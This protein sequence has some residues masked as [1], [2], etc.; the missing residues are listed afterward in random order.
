MAVSKVKAI[1]TICQRVT[2]TP[3]K[4]KSPY[5]RQIM[6]QN[7]KKYTCMYICKKQNKTKQKTLPVA[8]L[9]LKKKKYKL[10]YIIYIAINIS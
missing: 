1:R 6:I 2:E 4:N 9:L 7:I 8:V 10:I 5:L 3:Y